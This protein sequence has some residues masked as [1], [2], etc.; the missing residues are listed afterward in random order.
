MVKAGLERFAQSLAKAVQDDNITG[1]ILFDEDLARDKGLEPRL[2]WRPAA[3]CVS[4]P[5]CRPRPPSRW[6]RR[7]RRTRRRVG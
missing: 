3:C 5:P 6:T 7:T 2:G 4:R 1:H